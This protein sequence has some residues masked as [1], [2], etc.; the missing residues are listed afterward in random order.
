MIESVRKDLLNIIEELIPLY[1]AYK[2]DAIKA[3]SNRIIHSASV[4]QDNVS[5]K[6]ATII[7]S[8]GKLIDKGKTKNYAQSKWESFKKVLTPEL[9]RTKESLIKDD[10]KKLMKSL[11]RIEKA[12]QK[13]D[14]SYSDYVEFVIDK[15]K[16][17]KGAK[18][19]EH[20]VSLRQVSEL[21]GISEWDLMNYS[22]KTKVVDKDLMKS[23]VKKRLR[24]AEELLS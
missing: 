1:E 7:Y 16:L 17:K 9:R 18:I 2:S 3:L 22:G 19:H 11:N 20:G 14:A 12:I 15:A 6:A 8:I 21:L 4:Y 5:V 23:D 13:L 10:E 24:N